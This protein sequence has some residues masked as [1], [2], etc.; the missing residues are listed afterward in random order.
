MGG[1]AMKTS[2][3]IA[4]LMFAALAPALACDYHSTHTTAAQNSSVVA[5]AGGKCEARAPQQAGGSAETR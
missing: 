2:M 5:C 3:L 1:H 4:A